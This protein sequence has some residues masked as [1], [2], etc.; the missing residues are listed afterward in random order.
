MIKLF[1]DIE[2][3][4][5]PESFKD[6]LAKGIQ[7]QDLNLESIQKWE[8]KI[9]DEYLKTSLN[10]NFGRILCIAYIKEIPPDM[11]RDIIKG[12]ESAILKKF[13][14]V[15]KDVELFIGHN[16][17]DFD[18]KFIFKRS[19]VHRIKPSR[20]ITFARYRSS[21][22]YD[23]MQEW[24]KWDT[25]EKMIGLD[26]LA[27]VLGLHS[28]KGVLDGSKVYEFYKQGRLEEIYKYCMD[29]VELTREI[30]NRL[31]FTS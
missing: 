25:R 10:G 31:I 14:E 13:W 30:Y 17:L 26:K 27:R 12:K 19:V 2:T 7:P 22:V 15:A 18:L 6:E 23:T 9:E 24:R 11:E 29:D 8:E 20:E 1:L 4:P 5:A 16:I 21:P 3:I 28:S